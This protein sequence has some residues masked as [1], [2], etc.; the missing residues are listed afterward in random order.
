[1]DR[2]CT[3]QQGLALGLAEGGG[4]FLLKNVKLYLLI[5]FRIF[6][7]VHLPSKK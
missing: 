4:I 7:G 1:M 2:T 3:G 6:L 5:G